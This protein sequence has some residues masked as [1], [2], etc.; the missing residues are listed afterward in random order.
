MHPLIFYL[1][2]KARQAAQDPNETVT[3]SELLEEVGLLN[4]NKFVY[5]FFSVAF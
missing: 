5:L 1:A 3:E 2:R 4:P